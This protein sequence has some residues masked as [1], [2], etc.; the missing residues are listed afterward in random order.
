MSRMMGEI[1]VKIRRL[2]SFV[3]ESF[4][5][6]SNTPVTTSHVFSTLNTLLVEG[7]TQDDLLLCFYTQLVERV[8]Q[9]WRH[10]RIDI[11]TFS[12]RG[13]RHIGCG[14]RH[15]YA[16]FPEDSHTELAAKFFVMTVS[17]AIP[18][19]PQRILSILSFLT[20]Y[21]VGQHLK[22]H[23]NVFA[24]I[25]IYYT[26]SHGILCST[27][28]A[29]TLCHVDMNQV[30]IIDIAKQLVQ[31]IHVTHLSNI[32]HRDIKPNNIVF[33]QHG[34]DKIAVIDWGNAT[35]KIPS[36]THILAVTNPVTTLPFAAPELL[37]Q[38]ECDSVVYDATLLDTWSVGCIILFMMYDNSYDQYPFRGSCVSEI[39]HKI[40]RFSQSNI[41]PHKYT[42][43]ESYSTL[44]T[45]VRR[46]LC[47]D[48][49]R[50]LSLQQA[51]SMLQ[52]D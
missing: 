16:V 14:N 35:F 5:Q 4:I 41:L 1:T 25:G 23:P 21:R 20:E 22:N 19:L 6:L 7:V 24:P 32:A 51:F 9:V 47:V 13:K 11:S 18:C 45:V 48:P 17:C 52:C 38:H 50:R 42:S 28:G 33:Q 49:R 46:L 27:L 8:R 31:T 29:H 36:T 3:L 26:D 10:R 39:Y 43:V 34:G 40:L 12:Q 15:V 37:L 44:C 30:D 2:A